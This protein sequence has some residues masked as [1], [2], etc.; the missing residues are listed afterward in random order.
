MNSLTARIFI[1]ETER[2]RFV[3][4]RIEADEFYVKYNEIVE[5]TSFT[6]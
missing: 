5:D 6:E 4:R 2:G 1:D 3:I